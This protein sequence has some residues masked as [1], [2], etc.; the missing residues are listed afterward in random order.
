MLTKLIVDR[1]A[2]VISKSSWTGN[3]LSVRHRFSFTSVFR[4]L[5]SIL[6]NIILNVNMRFLQRSRLLLL[7][8]SHHHVAA[9]LAPGL[10]WWEVDVSLHITESSAGQEPT[11]MKLGGYIEERYF[12]LLPWLGGLSLP[13]AN[14]FSLEIQKRKVQTLYTLKCKYIPPPGSET[15]FFSSTTLEW[16]Q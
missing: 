6:M 8:Y 13:R 5:L 15:L 4:F 1:H 16:F 7:M 3:T 11:E 10:T 14:N 12:L 2:Q 9:V